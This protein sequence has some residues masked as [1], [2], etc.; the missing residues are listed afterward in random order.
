MNKAKILFFLLLIAFFS[1]LNA[2]TLKE[3][4]SQYGRDYVVSN[5]NEF[6]KKLNDAD[7]IILAQLMIRDGK[8]FET[9]KIL[10]P[11]ATNGNTRAMTLLAQKYNVGINGI[12]L[13]KNQAKSWSTKIE[14]IFNSQSGDKE[15]LAG[16]LCEIYKNKNGAL[17]NQAKELKY[18]KVY[19][20][21]G[22]ADSNY[23]YYLLNRYSP[24]Y[25]PEKGLAL[26]KKCIGE[27]NSFCK[28]NFGWQGKISPDIAKISSSKQL[29][30]YASAD[31][32]KN[33]P[34][35]LNNLGTFYEEGLGTAPDLSKAIELY[36][37]AAN[38]GRQYGFYNLLRSAFFKPGIWKDGPK[39]V[40]Q[41]SAFLA[42][43]DYFSDSNDR[44]DSV[45][46]KQW[47][48]ENKRLPSNNTE[49]ESFLMDKANKGDAAAACML[50]AHLTKSHQ[51]QDS[52]KYA[53]M[54]K[55]SSDRNVQEWCSREVD[56]IN[57]SLILEGMKPISTN[58]ANNSRL[59]ISEAEFS[60]QFQCPQYLSSDRER[61]LAIDYMMQ[62]LGANSKN[63][64]TPDSLIAF[65]M[66]MLKEHRCETTL[67]NI[68]QNSSN[69][70]Q[71]D[72][73][74]ISQKTASD[75][76]KRFKGVME[77][78]GMSGVTVDVQKCYDDALSKSNEQDLIRACMLYDKAAKALDLGFA[79]AMVAR[80]SKDPG[81]AN[82]YLTSKA[83]EVR[84]KIYSEIAFKGFTPAQVKSYFGDYPSKL[85]D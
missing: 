53:L 1:K 38:S 72:N 77:K 19:Y 64:V 79:Q 46:F 44:S 16:S 54:G 68:Q 60:K 20:E 78:S 56:R 17:Y 57:A 30:E 48:F 12:P 75:I 10:L 67:N 45:P 28:W 8:G 62:W 59:N 63:P 85:I 76:S 13:D 66:K 11:L 14:E 26:Y 81:P 61:E 43:Y 2:E 40:E 3:S 39:N 49:F 23:A 41:A 31:I 37:K 83:Y 65:R 58:E 22:K 35:A 33:N 7:I 84:M 73:I 24:F 4:I 21:S 51:A 71:Q 70:T 9:P 18:C 50:S 82:S 27:G 55:K 29:F 32:E 47:L 15:S 34:T 25:D 36:E 6:V 5:P 52:M 69:N 74:K 80:G 42:Y